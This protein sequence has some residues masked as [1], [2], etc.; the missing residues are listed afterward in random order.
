MTSK[1]DVRAVAAAIATVVV[2]STA[3]GL[4][5]RVLNE[6]VLQPGQVAL[7]RFLF[8]SATMGI[9]AVIT[10]M[11]MPSREDVPRIAV[12]ALFGITLYH[13]AFTFGES[14]FGVAPVSAGAASDRQLSRSGTTTSSTTK[15]WLPVPRIPITCQVSTIVTDSRGTQTARS[16]GAPAGVTIGVSFS[17]MPTSLLHPQLH[18]CAEPAEAFAN[19]P[20]PSA[21][22]HLPRSFTSTAT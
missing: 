18:P 8:A 11:R 9:I 6:G 14:P 21:I 5:V 4:I 1:T 13:L 3:F 22:E 15:S 2:W 10:R 20:H 7:L 12:A 17:I 16:T 19:S